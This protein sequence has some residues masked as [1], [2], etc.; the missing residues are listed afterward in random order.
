[1]FCTKCGKQI[2]DDS[3]FCPECGAAIRSE[4]SPVIAAARGGDVSSGMNVGIIAASI[5]V[6]LVGI[7]MGIIYMRDANPSKQ[8]AGK[9]W[10][11]VGIVALIIWAIVAAEG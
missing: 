7:I 2:P 6:P 3:V 11:I 4:Q 9:V 5:F 8:K 1:M 10:L